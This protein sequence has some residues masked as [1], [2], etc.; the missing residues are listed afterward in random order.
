MRANGLK[1]ISEMCVELN[2]ILI[3]SLQPTMTMERG[4]NLEIIFFS[5]HIECVGDDCS[6]HSE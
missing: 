4:K 2:A 6:E 3:S 1:I 5:S